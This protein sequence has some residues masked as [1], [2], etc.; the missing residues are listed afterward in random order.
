MFLSMLALDFNFNIPIELI[1]TKLLKKILRLIVDTQKQPSGSKIF[2][3]I[4]KK[5]RFVGAK[6]CKKVIKCNK[7]K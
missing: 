7:C 3:E 1:N 5:D 4:R 6:N 2:A